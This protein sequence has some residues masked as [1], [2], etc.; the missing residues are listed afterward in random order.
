VASLVADM[1]RTGI[2]GVGLKDAMAAL[3]RD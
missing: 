3:P 2:S 1:L